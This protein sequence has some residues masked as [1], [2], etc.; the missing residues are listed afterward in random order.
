MPWTVLTYSLPSTPRS[1]PRVA[2]WRRLRRLGAMSPTGSIYIL[3]GQAECVE[4]F[5]WLA[6]EIRHAQG[7]ALVMHVEQFDDLADSQLIELFR[8]ARDEEYGE[9]EPQLVDLEQAVT[10]SLESEGYYPDLLDKLDKLRRRYTDIKRVDYFHS[11]AGDRLAAR[12]AALQQNL[13]SNKAAIISVPI[14][15]LAEYREKRWVTRPRPHV[16]RLA[17]AWL[18]RRFINP[19]AAIRYALEPEPDEISFDMSQA[20]FGHEGRFCT[21][22]TML[23]AFQ[24]AEPGLQTMAE[25]VHEI[26]LRDGQY[27][28]PEV[29]GI[30]AI[31]RGW[32]AANFSDAELETYGVALFEGLYSMYSQKGS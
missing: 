14:A 21:F 8:Q 12:L 32:L 18:I 30:D 16:D 28:H 29:A 11:P 15:S 24:L 27:V 10:V 4:A 6:Q 9:I 7:E 3:P 19:K 20:H 25:I 22:E 1:S 13:T 2:L 26:D 5:Q 17:C 23:R 31:L